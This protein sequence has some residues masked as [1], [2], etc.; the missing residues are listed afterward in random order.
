MARR[1]KARFSKGIIE[2]L[3][4]LELEEGKE[5]IVTITEPSL[6]T[7]V[8][9][10]KRSAGGWRGTINAEKLIEDIYT[11]RLISRAEIKL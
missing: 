6:E 8:D 3:E 4:R 11:D 1:I 10:F 9:T 2:P 7:A 5:V